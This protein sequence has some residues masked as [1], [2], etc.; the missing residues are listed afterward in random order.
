MGKT[1]TRIQLQI[2]VGQKP[3]MLW[4]KFGSNLQAHR[5]DHDL[6]ILCFVEQ[7]LAKVKCLTDTPNYG[8]RKR[9]LMALQFFTNIYVR[10]NLIFTDTCGFPCFWTSICANEQTSPT[11]VT[12]TVNLW[13]K[14]MMSA[15]LCRSRKHNMNGVTIGLSSSSIRNVYRMHKICQ[16]HRRRHSEKNEMSIKCN[17]QMQ[18]SHFFA[19]AA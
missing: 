4:E 11:P 1:C 9:R 8:T 14:S 3:L 17:A 18:M 6:V 12:S 7:L 19:N 13:Q 10:I 15:A 2:Q 16:C 5:A